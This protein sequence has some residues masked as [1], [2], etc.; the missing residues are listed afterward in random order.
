MS[1]GQP[2]RFLNLLYPLFTKENCPK[3]LKTK[4]R[5]ESLRV[6]NGPENKVVYEFI[7]NLK[8]NK[9]KNLDVLVFKEVE[10][11]AYPD[12]TV[13]IY[14]KLKLQ[15]LKPHK[16]ITMADLD[17][18]H[19]I[20]CKGSYTFKL[21]TAKDQK[22]S[23]RKR[24][25]KNSKVAIDA[26]IKRDRARYLRRLKSLK[27]LVRVGYL[28]CSDDKYTVSDFLS[29]MQVFTIEAKMALNEDVY[30][31]ANLNACFC[32]DAFILVPKIPQKLVKPTWFCGEFPPRTSQDAT[33]HYQQKTENNLHYLFYLNEWSYHC[34]T[35]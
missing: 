23:I 24:L 29:I 6:K 19:D 11:A 8:V 15:T 31:Q 2:R 33:F 22:E 1:T 7:E 30:Q 26:A 14:D 5:S 9:P 10:G 18:V 28:D 25:D 20:Y 34:L 4:F 32:G 35:Q 13:V 27:E 3:C 17:L 21:K 12:L 16:L